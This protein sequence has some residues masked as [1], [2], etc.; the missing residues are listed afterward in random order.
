MPLSGHCLAS[1]ERLQRVKS[2][3]SFR[4]AEWTKGC[5]AVTGDSAESGAQNLFVPTAQ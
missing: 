1:P 2:G 5:K 3:R 4:G